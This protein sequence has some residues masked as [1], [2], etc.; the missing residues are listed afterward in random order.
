VLDGAL[1]RRHLGDFEAPVDSFTCRCNPPADPG[2]AE[3]THRLT[4]DEALE[5]SKVLKVTT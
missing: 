3:D 4:Y 5:R 1:F 2:G